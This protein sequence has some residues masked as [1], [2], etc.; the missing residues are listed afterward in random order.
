MPRAAKLA[1]FIAPTEATATIV[2]RPASRCRL[3]S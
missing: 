2:R 3:V 1:I